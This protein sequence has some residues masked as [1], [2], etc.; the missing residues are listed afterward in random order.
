ML[1]I[2]IEIKNPNVPNAK[3]PIA[4]TFATISNSF[5]EGFFKVCQT[6][7]HLI[8]NDFDFIHNPME[9]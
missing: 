5:L 3:I 1:F 4:E 7:L 8:K 6:R 2:I 9:K